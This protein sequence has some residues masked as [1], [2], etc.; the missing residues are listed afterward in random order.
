MCSTR[1][2][3]SSWR[4]RFADRQVAHAEGARELLDP[5]ALP[6]CERAADD[7]FVQRRERLLAQCAMAVEG[8]DGPRLRGWLW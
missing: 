3:L 4:H 6:G 5:Q 8:G 2:R 7:R 1:P